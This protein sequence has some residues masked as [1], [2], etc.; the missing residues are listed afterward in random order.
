[1]LKDPVKRP[2]IKQILQLPIIESAITSLSQEVKEVDTQYQKLLK[3]YKKIKHD[4]IKGPGKSDAQLKRRRTMAP[5]TSNAKKQVK[6]RRRV[7]TRFQRRMKYMKNKDLKAL[8]SDYQEEQ[9]PDVRSGKGAKTRKKNVQAK[10]SQK[11]S[12]KNK[13]NADHKKRF[14]VYD[15]RIKRGNKKTPYD[16]FEEED[17][18]EYAHKYETKSEDQKFPSDLLIYN[19]FANDDDDNSYKL[20]EI[21]DLPS[22]FQKKVQISSEEEQE[23]IPNYY[24]D[25]KKPVDDPGL[26]TFLADFEQEIN[27]LQDIKNRL[28]RIRER[29]STNDVASKVPSFGFNEPI[30]PKKKP[31]MRSAAMDSLEYLKPSEHR[32]KSFNFQKQRN[33]NTEMKG[34]KTPKKRSNLSSLEKKMYKNKLSSGKGKD[35][36]KIEIFTQGK[37][38]N[39]NYTDEEQKPKR[40]KQSNYLITEESTNH[41]SRSAQQEDQKSPVRVRK[42]NARK[43]NYLKKNKKSVA[44]PKKFSTYTKLNEKKEKKPQKEKTRQSKSPKLF[45]NETFGFGESGNNYN[46]AV[47]YVEKKETREKEFDKDFKILADLDKK[48]KFLENKFA[49]PENQP[50]NRNP[51]PE[52]SY[53]KKM[54]DLGKYDFQYI[55]DFRR[56]D[57][58]GNYNYD[59]PQKK[60]EDAFGNNYNDVSGFDDID[61]ISQDDFDNYANDTQNSD[62]GDNFD[63]FGYDNYQRRKSARKRLR[64]LNMRRKEKNHGDGYSGGYYR[65]QSPADDIDDVKQEVNQLKVGADLIKEMLRNK[66]KDL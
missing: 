40:K 25:H 45:K 16:I 39:K 27:R 26:L 65:D 48:Y 7:K 53:Y 32:F 64:N 51:S 20:P 6:P 28:K 33:K 37:N 34:A 61:E 43:K 46:I 31:V 10:D 60:R 55:E 41:K 57:S 59:V 44:Q 12:K 5:R 56:Q 18:D 66:I 24:D 1:M 21:P 19:A 23:I 63:D 3:R 58:K 17:E 62:K 47:P 29:K 8:D 13:S 50:Q 35:D 42:A 4:A 36:F 54:E 22:K 30:P 11:P 15:A 49:V 38:Q 9:V 2:N 14:S 52:D